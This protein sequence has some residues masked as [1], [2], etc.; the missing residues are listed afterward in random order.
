MRAHT[1]L[2]MAALVGAAACNRAAPTQSSAGQ[3]PQLEAPAPEAEPTRAFAPANPAA[4]AASGALNVSITTRMPD[5]AQADQGAAA[6]D[7][8]TLTGANHLVLE[9]ESFSTVSPA[10]QVERQT[11]RALMSLPVDA[12]QVVVYKVSSET[13]P[14][15]GQGVCGA[16]SPAYVLVW[17]PDTPGDASLKIM[18]VKNAVPGAAGAQACPSLEYGRQ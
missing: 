8:L 17:E 15:S 11:I 4:T 18:G 6:H 7:V 13:K 16:D 5:A 12:A 10:T 14:E 3:G 2:I 1:L 9:A